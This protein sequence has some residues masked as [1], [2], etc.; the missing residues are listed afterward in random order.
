M[1]FIH[2]SD[3]HI[4][5]RLCET[6]LSAD[7][8]YAL[9]DEILGRIYREA[10]EEKKP[11]ALVIAGDIYDKSLPSAEAEETFGRFLTRAAEL[12]MK[13]YVISGN[14]DSA[15]RLASNSGLLSQLGIYISLPFS[16]EEPVRVERLGDI[17]I[18]LMPFVSLSDV[19]GAYPE[20]DIQ[21]ITGAVEAVLRHS[22]LPAE[23]PCVLAAHQAVG[24]VGGIVGTAECVD[25]SVFSG[26]AYTFMGHIHTPADCAEN[27]RYCG[28]PVCFS[29]RE[30]KNPQK[31]CDI[32]DIEADGTACV[33]HREIVPLRKFCTME[34]SFERL[35]SDEYPENTDYCY[36]TVSG[37]DGVEGVAAQL[38][39][40]FPYMLSLQ[41]RN[42][43]RAAD[44]PESDGEERDFRADFS[45]FYRTVTH[46][47]IDEDLL[48]SA[49]Y[50]FGLTEEAFAGGEL[51]DGG[52]DGLPCAA[53]GGDGL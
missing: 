3:L 10:A 28:S 11:D 33:K 49:E 31:Y 42:E 35:M 50:I 37:I 4:G 39:S 14:H 30:A 25:V 29:G 26:F 1:R 15:R 41:Y 47:D 6:D 17:D 40:K 5:K 53:V 12:G 46:T 27:V 34:D 45:D 8:E 19:R 32:V 22:G 16:A 20:E 21:D 24:G 13:I 23:R 38:R 44:L 9:F 18:A 52:I 2:I 43:S 51:P 7:I 48:R 36:I